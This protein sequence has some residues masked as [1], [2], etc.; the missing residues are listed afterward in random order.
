[1]RILLVDDDPSVLESL[2]R[3]LTGLASSTWE[4]T[5]TNSG[6]EALAIMAAKTIDVIVTDLKMPRMDG[7]A[8]LTSV[9]ASWPRV[10]RIALSGDVTEVLAVRAAGVAH[11]LLAKPCPAHTILAVL[12]RVDV[13]GREESMAAARALISTAPDL[14]ALPAV[15]LEL[16]HILAD[17]RSDS[18]EVARILRQD[19]II[20]AKVMQLANSSFFTGGG[21]ISDVASAVS[22]LGVRTIS[23][24]ALVEGF[25]SAAK[26]AARFGF[27]QNARE[28]FRMSLVAE[29]TVSST[30]RDAASLAVLLCPIGKLVMICADPAGVDRVIDLA[31]S[32]SRPLEWA[33]SEVFGAS[34]AM[35]GSCLLAL[36]GLPPEVTA[37]VASQAASS[38][39]TDEATAATRLAHH[40]V[41]GG[42]LEPGAVPHELAASWKRHASRIDR[43]P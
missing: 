19:P 34:H 8:L 1:M 41:Y 15:F 36:W 12:D 37:A 11:Q 14:P 18:R 17:P 25:A 40:S 21:R 10:A 2:S 20:T 22:R 28:F 23:N 31:A 24:F 9:A 7:A 42:D 33:E 38:P 6:S 32:A 26:P 13:S 16:R 39:S 27:E 4:F 3:V 30:A 5:C 43:M 35:V 29:A